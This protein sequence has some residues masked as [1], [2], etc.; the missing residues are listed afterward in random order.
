MSVDFD[1]AGRHG[2][3][4]FLEE[5]LI[6]DYGLV[7]SPEVMAKKLKV[8]TMDLFLTVHQ[9]LFDVLEL[10]GL[11]VD[12]CDVFISCLDYHFDGAYSLKMIHW[13]AS[14]VMLD[15]SKKQ[16]NLHLN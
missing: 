14:D 7:F 12:Y 2:T 16:T 1:A 9:I 13:S 10:C 4:S 6:M 5:V 3:D 15:L 11:L 8:L